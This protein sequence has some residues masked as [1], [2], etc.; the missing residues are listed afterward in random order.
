ME[1]NKME[2]K[3]LG[4]VA[5]ITG[6]ARGIGREYALRL[7]RLGADVVITDLDVKA[8]K[9]K[10]KDVLAP[11]VKEEIEVLGRKSMA[12]EGD[13]TDDK[14]GKMVVDEVIKKFG[15]IDILINNVGGTG[16]AGP[17]LAT[18]M[19]T[20]KF[21]HAL[22]I[23]LL[24]TFIFCKYVGK[25][26]KKQKSG[27]II[28]I[29]S[30]GGSV[31]L[32]ITQAHYSAGKAGVDALT[33]TFAL[34][35]APYGVNVNAVAPGYIHTVKWDAHFEEQFSELTEKVPMG[36]LGNTEDCAKV[37]EFL[38][39]DLSDYLTGQTIYIDGGLK[40]LNPSSSKLNLY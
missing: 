29:S 9:F 34:E 37:I 39:T 5:L 14:F 2:E 3:L 20:D 11:T 40:T 36:R 21:V 23:N 10:E 30:V 26:M 16:G 35:L 6:A 28:N 24:S 22:H 33:R 15:H 18:E 38:A 8:T 19:D 4:K 27:K 12:F 31:P 7:A 17:A 32:F 25:Q 1:K 13:A